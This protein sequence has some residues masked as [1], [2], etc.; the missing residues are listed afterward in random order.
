[1]EGLKSILFERKK[2]LMDEYWGFLQNQEYISKM[3][4]LV[5]KYKGEATGMVHSS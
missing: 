4:I 3:L 2:Y 5:L 1:M